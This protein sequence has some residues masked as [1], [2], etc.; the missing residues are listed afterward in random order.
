ILL[1]V[2]HTTRALSFRLPHGPAVIVLDY[3]N[4]IGFIRRHLCPPRAGELINALSRHEIILS[5]KAA[6]VARRTYNPQAQRRSSPMPPV[7][8]LPP[9]SKGFGIR[10]SGQGT[11]ECPCLSHIPPTRGTFSLW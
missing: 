2:K 5:H 3:V 8:D 9:T 1:G 4:D 7:C 11:R 10:D 6:S